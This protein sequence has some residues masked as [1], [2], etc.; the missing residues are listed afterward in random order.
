M[1][2]FNIRRAIAGTALIAAGS[3]AL[4]ACSTGETNT[5]S[6]EEIRE[7]SEFFEVTRPDGKKMVCMSF[8]QKG[9][10]TYQGFS[11]FSVSCDWDQ[12][13]PVTEPVT[14]TTTTQPETS[15]TVNTIR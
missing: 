13:I 5:P 4:G 9:E 1:E 3:L 12:S 6:I 15:P 8:A 10:Q 14:T 11:W 2:K 7:E